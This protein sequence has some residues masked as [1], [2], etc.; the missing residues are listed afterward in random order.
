M[1]RRIRNLTQ[2]ERVTKVADPATQFQQAGLNI[3]YQYQPVETRLNPPIQLP[4][5]GELWA[6]VGQTA[7]EAGTM[8]M[9][10]PINPA[11]RK[12]LQARYKSAQEGINQFN[13]L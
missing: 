11:V 13:V 10:S 9:N 3:G 8:L 4:G 1:A 6:K 2:K 5:T 7:M 12:E